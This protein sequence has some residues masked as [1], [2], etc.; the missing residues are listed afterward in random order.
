MNIGVAILLWTLATNGYFNAPHTH[1]WTLVEETPISASDIPGY[2][3]NISIRE[4]SAFNERYGYNLSVPVVNFVDVPNP[5]YVPGYGICMTN[6][7]EYRQQSLYRL[8]KELRH[9]LCHY[10][11]YRVCGFGVGAESFCEVYANVNNSKCASQPEYCEPFVRD[12][13]VDRQGFIDCVFREACSFK[14]ATESELVGCYER[15]L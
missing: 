7:S 3:R 11:Q 13:L 1:I 10:F 6:A 2:A 4:V 15:Y 14:R 9:E 8:N 12:M 5:R